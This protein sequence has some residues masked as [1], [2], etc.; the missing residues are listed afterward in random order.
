MYPKEYIEY[1]VQFH[2]T[3][4]YFECHEILEEY[5]KGKG[6][7][8]PLWE[9]LIQL[10]VGYYHYRRNNWNGALKMIRNCEAIF[11]KER[12]LIPTL[13]LNDE[14]FF[15]ILEQAKK[16]IEQKIPYESIELPINDFK[17][18]N[19]VK[20]ICTQ[21]QLIWNRKSDLTNQYLIHKHKLRDRSEVIEARNHA[22]RKKKR[23]EENK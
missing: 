20:N 3:R 14:K 16:K 6:N 23:V 21:N 10:A 9:G 8:H 7:K 17:L 11:K 1:L 15:N 19:T 4:D 18:L 5:W 13:G 12:H 2:C 22:K